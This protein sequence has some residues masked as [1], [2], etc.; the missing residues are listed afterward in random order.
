[1]RIPINEVRAG[2]ILVFKGSGIFAFVLSRL[3]KALKEPSWDCWGWHTAPVI[4]PDIIVDAQWP[5]LKRARISDYVK[6]G[7]EIKAYRIMDLP[8]EDKLAGFAKEHIGRRYDWFV[9]ILT[10]LAQLLRP[11]FDFPRIIDLRFT[12]WEITF[13]FCDDMGLDISPPYNYPF[14]T[15]FLR[16]VGEL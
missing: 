3:I 6:A 13:D 9:Y 12:C 5:K 2:D 11:M 8:V 16:Y 14:I 4:A 7:R 10:T 1:M 15:D